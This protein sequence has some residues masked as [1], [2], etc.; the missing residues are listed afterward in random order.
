MRN[1]L[2]VTRT[3][4]AML[5]AL[6]V[7][8]LMLCPSVGQTRSDRS[9]GTTSR[10]EPVY[11]NPNPEQDKRDQQRIEWEKEDRQK[12]KTNEEAAETRAN[13]ARRESAYAQS[14]AKHKAKAKK[15]RKNS[16]NNGYPCEGKKAANKRQ[17]AA[18]Q[19]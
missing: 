7:I 14:K 1:F 2:K 13:D 8:G 5:A 17:R 15:M 19:H 18:A 16:S 12:A 11:A 10:G 3:Q 6:V 4:Y 9:V